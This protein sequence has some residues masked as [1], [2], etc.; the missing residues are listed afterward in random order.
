MY[1]KFTNEILQQLE[2]ILKLVVFLIKMRLKSNDK[3][4]MHKDFKEWVSACSSICWKQR[5]NVY[6]VVLLPL[7]SSNFHRMKPLKTSHTT[8]KQSPMHAFLTPYI[9]ISFYLSNRN[10]RLKLWLS[11][12]FNTQLSAWELNKQRRK[13]SESK[14]YSK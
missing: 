5:Q 1:I 6:K 14:K 11:Y 2:D 12:I 13:Y 3:F 4:N 9:K 7:G 10:W 8:T